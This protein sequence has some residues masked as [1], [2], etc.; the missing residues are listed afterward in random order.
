[1]AGRYPGELF[2]RVVGDERAAQALM[3][4]ARLVMGEAL[5]AAALGGTNTY[6]MRRKLQDGSIVVA[7][8]IGDLNR[9]TITPATTPAPPTGT[10]PGGGFI[11]WPRWN[12]IPGQASFRGDQ[13]DPDGEQPQ[14]WLEFVGNSKITRYFERWDVVDDIVGAR[15]ERFGVPDLYPEGLR[16]YG[17]TDWKDGDDLSVSYYNFVSRY[18]A[19]ATFGD[20]LARW[21]F[22]QGQVLFD[23]IAYVAGET[24]TPPDYLNWRISSA[25][26][27]RSAQGETQLLVTCSDNLT[28]RPTTAQTAFVTYRVVRNE[29][30]PEKGNWRIVQGSHTLLGMTP[31]KVNPEQPSNANDFGYSI[32]PWFFNSAGS[33]ATRTVSSEPTSTGG[34]LMNT[35]TE[36]VVITDA[37]IEYTAE[38]AAFMEANYENGP[39]SYQL[40]APARGLVAT[41]YAGTERKEAYINLRQSSGTWFFAGAQLNVE[42]V[43]EFDGGEIPLLVR[44]LDGSADV[45]DYH[46]LAYMDLRHNLFSGWRVQGTNGVHTIQPFAY[47]AGRMVYGLEEEVQWSPSSG[48][49]PPFPGLDTRANPGNVDG[50]VYGA[51]WTG[52]SGQGWGPRLPNTGY[53]WRRHPRQALGAFTAT[54][55]IVTLMQARHGCMDFAGFYWPG[56]WNFNKGRYCVSMP[57][58][59]GTAMNYLTGGNMGELLGITAEDQ[60][61]WPLAVL[62]KAI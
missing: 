46:Q 59:Y 61:F 32:S 21:V 10:E 53:S 39:S 8:K 28:N 52:A 15:F 16:Y 1:M 44:R 62:P 43:L 9:V 14:A 22:S 60:R 45:Q 54:A 25:C 27:R 35:V 4:A 31:G 12:V 30:D 20:G 2:V 13:V 36:N 37:G 56:G 41:D 42:I 57:G 29:S 47:M 19:D 48:V 17:C 5:E 40:L 24:E 18:L 55:A 3:P 51:Y 6:T 58:A 49:A 7:E 26:F 50:L 38:Q 23:R 33:A 34:S 11:L